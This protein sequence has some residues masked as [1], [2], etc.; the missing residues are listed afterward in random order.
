MYTPWVFRPREAITREVTGRERVCVAGGSVTHSSVGLGQ[1]CTLWAP[2]RALRGRFWHG[3][4]GTGWP[5]L[6]TVIEDPK[7]SNT[8]QKARK[9]KTAAS[10]PQRGVEATFCGCPEGS[11]PP[12]GRA[13]RVIKQ[14]LQPGP[15]TFS[16]CLPQLYQPSVTQT[17]IYI[18][19]LS[20]H[21]LSA[22][23]P[24]GT[25]RCQGFHKRQEEPSS[26]AISVHGGRENSSDHAQR[27]AKHI[28]DKYQE[29]EK[30]G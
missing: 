12:Q 18:C 9:T 27:N 11:F 15:S 21:L 17:K 23:S 20:R 4:S 28:L 10:G 1:G 22:Q 13:T 14:E 26:S 2:A 25:A 19:P 3:Q 24:C 30:E 16:T 29:A 7:E 6:S 5:S 8:T